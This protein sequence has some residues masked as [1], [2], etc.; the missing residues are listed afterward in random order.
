VGGLRLWAEAP[1]SPQKIVERIPAG[2]NFRHH[3]VH[4]GAELVDIGLVFGRNEYF[5][6][7]CAGRA[8][9]VGLICFLS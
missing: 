8:F 4:I 2:V 6:Y 1:Q 5:A 7:I 9:F 3:A